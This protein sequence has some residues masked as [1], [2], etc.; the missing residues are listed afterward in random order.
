MTALTEEGSFKGPDLNVALICRDCKVDPPELIERFSEGDVICGLCG[1]VLSEHIVDMRSEWRTFN[2]DDQNGDDPSRVG[3]A[4]NPLLDGDQLSTIIAYNTDNTRMGRELS[5]A[6]NSTVADRK[7]S[8]LQ[9]AFAKISQLCEGFQ[10]PNIVQNGA[11]EVYKLVYNERSLKGKSQES[12]MAAAI[13]LACRKANV[14]RSFKELW[15]LTDVPK[16][17]IGKV[18]KIIHK[19]IQQKHA[20]AGGLLNVQNESIATTQTN[21]EALIGRFCSNLGLSRQITNAAEYIARRTKEVGVLAGRSPV[22]VAATVIYMA[23]SI[24]DAS[25]SPAQIAQRA[26]VSD[27]TIKTSYKYLYDKRE[28]LVDPQWIE[29]GKV[30]LEN[31]PKN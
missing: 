22:T 21:A 16:N 15:A 8:A 6:Q 23:A 30:K 19:L 20:L 29:S 24:F 18:F 17:E 13:G 27:G 26:G 7:D 4:Q 25:I 2:N 10:L 28:E 14:P 3:E 12:I 31:I 5:R 9:A 11:K 1:L